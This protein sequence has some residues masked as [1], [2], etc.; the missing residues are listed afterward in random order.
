MTEKRT[1]SFSFAEYSSAEE[2]DAED[3]KLV[4]AAKEASLRAYAP[5]SGFMVGAAVRLE[6]GRIIHGSNVENA[7][8]PSGTCAE[9][10]ALAWTASNYPDDKPSAIAI[11]AMTEEGVVAEPVTPCGNCRQVIAEEEIRTGKQIRIILSCINKIWVFESIEP[12]LPFQF[13]NNSFRKDR[14]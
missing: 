13:N 4:K 14:S 5:Y 11:T 6:S 12:L 9:I 8:F 7:A 3:Q 1:I 10:S 2:L